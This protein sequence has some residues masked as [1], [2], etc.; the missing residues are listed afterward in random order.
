MIVRISTQYNLHRAD[1]GRLSSGLDKSDEDKTKDKVQQLHNVP[2]KIRDMMVA[3][4]G[5]TLVAADY[6]AIEWCVMMWYGSRLPSSN[7]F[8]LNLLRR[9]R[10]KELDPH[11]FLASYV[12]GVPEE[13]ITRKQRQDAK[14]FTY[15][16]WDNAISVGRRVGIRDNIASAIGRA[17]E[18]AF[19]MDEIRTWMLATTKKQHYAETALGFRRYFWEWNPKPEEVYAHYGQGTAADLLKWMLIRLG[20]SYPWEILTST[21]DSVVTLVPN[22][23]VP[24]SQTLL[25]K[26]LEQP[27]PWMDNHS[28]RV[29]LKSG[30][31]WKRVS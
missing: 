11:T 21:H 1:S 7:G 18:K 24:K 25:P 9:F 26:I 16:F 27:I 23:D 31:N 2:R 15:G 22:A 12:Y 8:H 19:R 29:D 10:D 30:P 4:L 13:R 28:W 5:F 6:A 17:H 20:E 14:P 3:P